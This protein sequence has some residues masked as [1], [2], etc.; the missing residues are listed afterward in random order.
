MNAISLA[1]TLGGLTFVI[2]SLLTI[3]VVPNLLSLLGLPGVGD[4]VNF[5]RWPV[6]LVS[7]LNDRG[8]LSVRS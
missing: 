5:A 2:A 3:T 1:L 7:R 6:L 8:D 4:I